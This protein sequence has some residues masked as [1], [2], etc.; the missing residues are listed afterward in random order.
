MADEARL[1][2]LVEQ[3]NDALGD[4]TPYRLAVVPPGDVL[5]IDKNARYMSKRTYDQL[6]ANVGKD[7]NLSSI[8]FCWKGPDGRFVAL[9]GNHR[10]MAAKDA[11]VLLILVLYTDAKLSKAKQRAIQLSHNALVG[12]DNPTTLRELWQEIDDLGMKIYSG[13]DDGLIE[14]M[15]KVNV[16]RIAEEALRFQELTI[17]FMA[18]E[19]DRIK[20]VLKQL[21]SV[22]KPRLAARY[23]DFDRFFETLLDFKEAANMV[24]TGTAIMAMIEIVEAWIAEHNAVEHTS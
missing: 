5:P 9:S 24:N 22:N 17:L 10:V 13:L 12:Q 14:T 2:D 6:V 1:S 15:E 18:S 16:Q 20:D 3:L 19:I 21:G 11:G 23:E 4:V 7:K 8:P